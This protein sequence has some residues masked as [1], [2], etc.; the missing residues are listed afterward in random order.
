MQGMMMF[1]EEW[2]GIRIQDI[3]IQGLELNGVWI[4]TI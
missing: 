2:N 4:W 3:Q 1:L